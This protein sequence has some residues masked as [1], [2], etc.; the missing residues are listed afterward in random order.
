MGLRLYQPPVESD[1]PCKPAVDRTAAQSRSSIRR[2]RIMRE[3]TDR[4]RE[5]R[6]RILGSPDRVGG[7]S[8][9]A[10]SEP[11]HRAALRD[12]ASHA[13]GLPSDRLAVM[14]GDRWARFRAGTNPNPPHDD[15]N[16]PSP[17]LAMAVEPEFLSPNP[18]ALERAL[19]RSRY[20]PPSPPREGI[21]RGSRRPSNLQDD[22]ADRY[23]RR[24]T[25]GA[26]RR[27]D[28]PFAVEV[29]FLDGLGDR[30]RSLSP[31]GDSAWD[32]LLTTL[33]PDPQPP[34]V[35]SSFASTRAASSQRTAA[36]SS[37]SRTSF[38]APDAA[39]GEEESALEHPCESG[40]D[41]SDTEGEDVDETDRPNVFAG[42]YLR[43]GRRRYP[44]GG[45]GDESL[46]LLSGLG[47][48][49]RIVHNLSAREDIRDEWW[50]D[51]G[52]TRTDLS[53]EG[54]SNS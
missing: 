41:N 24:P 11:R 51:V 7:S 17:V 44:V 13:A 34:S 1:I 49:Q 25:G 54:S 39:M 38:T 37:S 5:R 52:L 46:E 33:T 21:Y 29:S 45:A 2:A 10:G 12:M 15:D 20:A 16:D 35:G 48:M 6:R 18:S 40:R 32:T 3:A 50:P 42:I 14:F 23:R 4:L 43:G 8:A 36:T 53:R 19:S 30:T 27:S 28:A 47:G 9:T 31:E 22:A 26:A